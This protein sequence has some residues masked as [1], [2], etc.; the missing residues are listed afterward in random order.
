MKLLNTL[1]QLTEF[2]AYTNFLKRNNKTANRKKIPLKL[3]SILK[4]YHLPLDHNQKHKSIEIHR[5]NFHNASDIHHCLFDIHQ[6][7]CNYLLQQYN[8]NNKIVE[9]DILYLQNE[10]RQ[11]V[12]IVLDE[13][14][15]DNKLN[16]IFCNL[17]L[18]S[19]LL[20]FID[21]LHILNYVNFCDMLTI[22]T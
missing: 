20:F 16:L 2:P 7:P 1:T 6:R 22:S 12:V 5:R 11:L 10:R 8:H 4:F 9:A 3:I 17:K 15:C 21:T 14:N 13:I 18:N 19:K